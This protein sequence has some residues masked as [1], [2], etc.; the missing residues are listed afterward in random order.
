MSSRPVILL[1][2]CFALSCSFAG[3]ARA[4]AQ[5][6]GSPD[7][8]IPAQILSARKV[9]ISNGGAD[10]DPDIG[11]LGDFLGL[12]ARPYN[13]FYASM[14]AWGRYE[15]VSTPSDADLIFEIN[16]GLSRFPGRDAVAKFRLRVLDPKTGVLL[17]PFTEYVQG[18]FL[19]GNREKNFAAGM[20]S[21]LADVK[22]LASL[23]GTAPPNN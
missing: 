23:S 15:L 20:A 1:T 7:A 16:F 5:P 13:Q 12:P 18:A 4:Q 22:W 17:W 19:K 8:P 21:I 9:F 3:V 11:L 6:P 2:M 10:I 14:K